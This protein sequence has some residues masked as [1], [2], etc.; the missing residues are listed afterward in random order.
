MTVLSLNLQQIGN[1]N[2]KDK[3]REDLEPPHMTETYEV[4]FYSDVS[5]TKINEWSTEDRQE[6]SKLN[7]GLG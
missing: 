4:P 2:P 7:F 3:A 5:Y 6:W 1:K